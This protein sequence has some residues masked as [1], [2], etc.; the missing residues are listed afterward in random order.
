MKRHDRHEE[1]LLTA[2]ELFAER[3]FAT[4]TVK[5]IAQSLGVNPALVYYYFENKTALLRAAIE[6]IVAKSFEN[7]EALEKENCDPAQMI[8]SWLD[9]HVKNYS[10]IHRF[11]KIA[12]DFKSAHEGDDAIEATIARFYAEERKMLSRIIRR[13]VEARLFNR[14]DSDRMAQFIST[15]LDG[16]MVR[17]VILSN[18][19]LSVAVED[20]RRTIFEQLGLQVRPKAHNG[21]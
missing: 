6:F 11:V 2:L 7:I 4:V 1:F 5:D 14:I 20:L 9:N 21:A 16:C 12:L 10:E 13:G 19:K 3:N 17:S 18:F 15:F 8:A